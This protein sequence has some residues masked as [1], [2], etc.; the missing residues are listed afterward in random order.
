MRER[1]S[2]LLRAFALGLA[3][4]T[5]RPHG[6]AAQAAPFRFEV[7]FFP[8]AAVLGGGAAIAVLPRVLEARLPHATCA[9]CDPAALRSVDRAVLGPLRLGPSTASYG[10]LLATGAAT[11]ILLSRSR[12]GE[13]GVVAQEDM[14]V[15]AEA[16]DVTAALTEWAKVLFRRPRP[17]RY[18]PEATQYLAPD[19]GLSFPSSHTSVAFAAA[20]A[21]A[22]IL[23]RRGLV[24]RHRSEVA[25]LFTGA[26]VTGTLRVVARKHFPTDVL[27]G[28][29]L[30]T[31]IGWVVP[32]VHATR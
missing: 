28:A 30:G 2:K 8:D 25:L 20:A 11:A 18:G 10:T 1:G 7:R 15:L 13:G 29:L 31:A 32:A 6:A 4:L 17:V 12:R 14:V 21:Y 19:N 9:P 27:A 26:A 22:S 5:L 3:G 16:L 24:G 23:D